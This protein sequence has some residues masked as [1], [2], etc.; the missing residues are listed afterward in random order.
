[1]PVNKKALLRYQIYDRC[2]RNPGRRYSQHDLLNEVN[3]ALEEEDFRGIGR[4]Q[5]YKDIDD[6]R[7]STWRAPI[8]KY[9]DGRTV[10]Y[11]YE[12][13]SFSINNQPLNEAEVNQIKSALLV[14]SRFK[15]MPQFEWVN[16]I[17][18][19]IESKLGLVGK[20]KE[21]ISF[22]HNLD[23]SGLDK[24]TP[25]FHAII[26]KCVLKITYQDFKSD[27][28]YAFIFH[29]YHLRQYNNRWFIFGHNQENEISCWNLALDRIIEIE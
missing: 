18:P 4:T 19:V 14:L 22:D 17:I 1:M 6:M 2:M 9:K 8:E 21:V 24:I 23:Y 29:P 12:D 13:Q 26:N 7:Y 10:Y 3:E 15:G 16:E 20:D 11:R 27:S 5:F 25:L 28:S